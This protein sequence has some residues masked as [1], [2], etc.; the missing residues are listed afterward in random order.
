MR[1]WTPKELARFRA[2]QHFEL[3]QLLGAHWLGQHVVFRVWAPH[4]H[5]VVV[6]G[7]FNGWDANATP[8]TRVLESDVWRVV[9]PMVS[10]GTC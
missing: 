10:V 3:H 6:V 2:G 4:A 8:M 1:K 9:V 7:D 5:Q